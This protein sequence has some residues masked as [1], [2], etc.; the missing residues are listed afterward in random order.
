MVN[1][2]MWEWGWGRCRVILGF[3][4]KED[5]EYWGKNKIKEVLRVM[6]LELDIF[7]MRCF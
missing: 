6:N 5:R 1:Y 3:W 2:D 7:S 4:F